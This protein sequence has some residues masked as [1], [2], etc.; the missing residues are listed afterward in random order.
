MRETIIFR[1]SSSSDPTVGSTIS[2]KELLEGKRLCYICYDYK[3]S[4]IDW[5]CK[6]GC[7]YEFCKDCKK[8]VGGLCPLCKEPYGSYKDS[9]DI[10]EDLQL[11]VSS[12][13]SLN[14]GPNFPK[15]IKIGPRVF[16]MSNQ[17]YKPKDIFPSEKES[18]GPIW[19]KIIL[20]NHTNHTAYESMV[21]IGTGKGLKLDIY[22]EWNDDLETGRFKICI[23][24]L[25]QE[26]KNNIERSHSFIGND[27]EKSVYIAYESF[28]NPS[29]SSSRKRE[30]DSAPP[31][32][33]SSQKAKRN[34]LSGPRSLSF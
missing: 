18:L 30:P 4:V 24:K 1:A 34:D 21:K 5:N 14:P 26:N 27:E 16:Y 7:I 9:S 31:V 22:E 6:R 3:D 33:Q 20:G 11:F 2:T 28:G 10:P 29:P 23:S 17:E 12:N 25:S 8:H 19:T 15:E 32:Q 13:Y